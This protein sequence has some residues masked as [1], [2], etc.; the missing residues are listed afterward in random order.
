MDQRQLKSLIAAG[1][2][3]ELVI[4][5]EPPATWGLLALGPDLPADLGKRLKV[6][7]HTARGETRRFKTLDA[8]AAMLADLGWT[9]PATLDTG[10]W[11]E[12]AAT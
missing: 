6:E 1:A 2:V 10:P 12:S 11:G 8:A 4:F 7:L 5:R 3:A 9:R